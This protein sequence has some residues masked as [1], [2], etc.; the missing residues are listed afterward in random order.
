MTEP[1]L[2]RGRPP[3]SAALALLQ[4]QALPAADITDEHLEHPFFFLRQTQ[5]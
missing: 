4:A 2:I 3:R 5:E 1:L